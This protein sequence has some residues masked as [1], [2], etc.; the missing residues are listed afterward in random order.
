MNKEGTAGY[1]TYAMMNA[2]TEMEHN[3][4]R[5]NRKMCIEK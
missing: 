2:A 1:K 3:T 4:N 5:T